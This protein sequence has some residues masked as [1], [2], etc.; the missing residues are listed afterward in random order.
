[1]KKERIKIDGIPAILWGNKSDTVYIAVHGNMSNK[2]DEVIKILAEK[3]DCFGIQVLSFDLPEHGERK[4]DKSYLCNPQNAIHDLN[5]ILDYA[6]TAYR[7]IKLW[8]CSMGA[9]FSMLAYNEEYIKKAVFLSPV[10]NMKV[11]IDGI[12]N[13]EGV[14]EEML[15][16]KQKIKTEIRP[17]TL[18]G[19]L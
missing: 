15:K 10:I 8:A 9:Y 19:L 16:E 11:I 5:V 17:S 3:L 6:K 1:M 4:D 7:E 14:T 18:L 12:M 2:E 13:M